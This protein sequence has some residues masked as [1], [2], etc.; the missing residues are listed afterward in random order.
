MRRGLQTD[1]DASARVAALCH[2][3]S[4]VLNTSTALVVFLMSLSTC[5]GMAR[6]AGVCNSGYE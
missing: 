1:S 2:H 5:S 6:P 4:A 3:W